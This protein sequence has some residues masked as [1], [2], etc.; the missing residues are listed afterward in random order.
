HGRLPI[1][2]ALVLAGLAIAWRRGA[3]APAR[4]AGAAFAVWLALYCG[5]PTWGVL[6]RLAGVPA[7]LQMPRLIG[8]GHFFGILPAGIAGGR[9]A[10]WIGTRLPETVR[11]GSIAAAAILLMP[12]AVERH[13]FVR[14]GDAWAVESEAAIARERGDL[15]QVHEK[16]RSLVAGDP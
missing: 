13:A 7:G 14:Q 8:G 6:L 16:L 1:V 3:A 12:P 11:A 9:L 4:F 15:D 2:T 5:R 10:A